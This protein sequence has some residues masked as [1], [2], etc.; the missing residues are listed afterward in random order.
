MEFLPTD[1]IFLLIFIK[2]V[3]TLKKALTGKIL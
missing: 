2:L 3:R 1:L